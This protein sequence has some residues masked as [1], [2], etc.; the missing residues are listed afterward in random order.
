MCLEITQQMV[1]LW[2]SP[3][4]MAWGGAERSLREASLVY[5]DRRDKPE[6]REWAGWRG[7]AGRKANQRLYSPRGLRSSLLG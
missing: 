5:S 4:V 3:S 6:R 2:R 7:K 1:H